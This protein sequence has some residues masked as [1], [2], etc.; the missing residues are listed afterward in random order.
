M[1]SCVRNTGRHHRHIHLRPTM[2]LHPMRMHVHTLVPSDASPSFLCRKKTAEGKAIG[3]G[4]RI[5][6]RTRIVEQVTVLVFV[7]EK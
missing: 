4:R 3:M 2:T 1:L 5:Y 7:S 6:G